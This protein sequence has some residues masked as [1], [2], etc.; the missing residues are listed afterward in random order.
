[1]IRYYPGDQRFEAVCVRRSHKFGPHNKNWCAT[2]RHGH[3]SNR[4]PAKGR[5]VGYLAAWLANCWHCAN[6]A[7]HMNPFALA[8]LT[9]DVRKAARQIVKTL[10]N[11]VALLGRER[12]QGT[13]PDSEP[14]EAPYS[15]LRSL[16]HHKLVS[17]SLVTQ[18]LHTR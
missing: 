7:D 1:M 8:V 11:G 13:D 18:Y 2:R 10:P 4:F 17:I 9:Q 3:K 16:V 14:E 5:P 15:H 12:D 6:H